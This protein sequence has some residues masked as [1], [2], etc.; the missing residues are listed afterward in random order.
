MSKFFL[1]PGTVE[2]YI[3]PYKL[4]NAKYLARWMVRAIVVVCVIG[5]VSGFV[6]GMMQ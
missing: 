2:R 4:R 5:F 3:A 6:R 1:A